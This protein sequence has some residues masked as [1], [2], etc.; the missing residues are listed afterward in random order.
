M[1]S[2]WLATRSTGLVS[3]LLLSA[4]V[5]F[6]VAY[7][8]G[9]GGR[10]FPRVITS[11]LHRRLSL[12][13]VVFLVLH[14][15]TIVLDGYAPVSMWDAV[16]PFGSAYKPFWIGIAAIATDLLIAVIVTS[17]LRTRIPERLWRGV[18][19]SAYVCWALAVVHALGAGTDKALS[20]AIVATSGI[21]VMAV[22][23]VRSSS[24][25]EVR[26]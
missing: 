6:G 24:M 25:K 14:I 4:V 21:A 8:G 20:L 12:L 1:N 17:A 10:R 3:L 15:G 5:V 23:G 19:L 22:L 11:G 16:V 7:A 26:A 2:L 9:W 18:H 13:A